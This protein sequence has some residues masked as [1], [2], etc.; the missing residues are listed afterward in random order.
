MSSQLF[1][2][3][4]N[5]IKWHNAFV[6]HKQQTLWVLDLDKTIKIWNQIQNVLCIMKMLAAKN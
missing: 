5:F 4:F 6:K 2:H 1:F 3:D